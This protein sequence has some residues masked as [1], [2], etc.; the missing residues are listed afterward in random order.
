MHEDQA[1][2][3]LTLDADSVDDN[4]NQHQTGMRKRSWFIDQYKRHGE[5]LKET[6]KRVDIILERK[7]KNGKS[8]DMLRWRFCLAIELVGCQGDRMAWGFTLLFLQQM[9]VE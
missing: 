1:Q 2:A 6:E 7:K 9:G 3:V 8:Y 4:T 5:N